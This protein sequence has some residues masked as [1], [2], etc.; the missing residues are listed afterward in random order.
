MNYNRVM[1]GGNITRE[2][3]VRYLESGMAIA[4]MGLAINRKWKS[5]SGDEKS[6]V[7]FVDCTLFGKTAESV[8][9][10]LKKGDPIFIEG[11]LKLD[12]WEKDGQKHQKLTVTVDSFQFIGGK[13]EESDKPDEDRPRPNAGKS[14]KQQARERPAP[15]VEMESGDIPF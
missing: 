3:E 12:Q 8:A 7:C 4:K 1:L 13:K 14:T 10:Y 9:K 15:D 6:E 5:E 2:I 11:R